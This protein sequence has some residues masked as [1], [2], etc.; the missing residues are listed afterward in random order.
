LAATL[1]GPD[2]IDRLRFFCGLSPNMDQCCWYRTNVGTL[3]RYAR[4][5]VRY[6]VHDPEQELIRLLPKTSPTEIESIS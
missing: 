2:A 6:F 1:A 4:H 5:M 3:L